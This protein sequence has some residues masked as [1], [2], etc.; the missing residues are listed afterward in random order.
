MKEDH[1]Y[2]SYDYAV[3]ELKA[4]IQ[5]TLDIVARLRGRLTIPQHQILMTHLGN[6]EF[7]LRAAFGEAKM[8]RRAK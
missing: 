6:A 5:N 3:D 4:D 2:E 8:L 1:V 7:H